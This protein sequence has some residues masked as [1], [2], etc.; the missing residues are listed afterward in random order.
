MDVLSRTDDTEG[1]DCTD[2]AGV[3]EIIDAIKGTGVKG[4]TDEAGRFGRSRG[5]L[6]EAAGKR[7]RARARPKEHPSK[8]TKARGRKCGDG[9]HW[10][11]GH[12]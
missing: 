9:P 4:F 1:L 5:R 12:K 8:R 11:S 2:P 6:I 7:T 10:L 3:P